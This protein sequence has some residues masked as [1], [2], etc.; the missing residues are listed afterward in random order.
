MLNDN[1]TGKK[2]QF[3]LNLKNSY[4]VQRTKMNYMEIE[5]RLKQDL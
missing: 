3:N 5:A 4:K 1:K 2:I